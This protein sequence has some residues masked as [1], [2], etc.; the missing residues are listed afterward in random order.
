MAKTRLTASDHALN[1][2]NLIGEASLNVLQPFQPPRS[3][4]P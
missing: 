1:G 3:P 2:L 4:A